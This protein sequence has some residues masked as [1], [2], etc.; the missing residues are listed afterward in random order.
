[1][2]EMDWGSTSSSISES[3][4]VEASLTSSSPAWRGGPEKPQE[5]TSV[6]T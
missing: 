5:S 6:E 2:D 1:M 4:P 3:Q